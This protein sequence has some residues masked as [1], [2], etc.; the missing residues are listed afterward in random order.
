MGQIIPIAPQETPEFFSAEK[1]L[2]HE[3]ESSGLYVFHG[4]AEDR[5]ELSPQQA[6][7]ILPE[8]VIPD[9]EPAVF[10]SSLAD[11]AIFMAI[12]NKNNCPRGTRSSVWTHTTEGERTLSYGATAETLEQ[13]TDTAHG[14]VY[15]FNKESFMQ[16]DPEDEVE[17]ISTSTVK[18]IQKVRVLKQDLPGQIDIIEGQQQ[19]LLQ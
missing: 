7:N 11:Y 6:H 18:P 5:E 19:S 9:G 4:S 13:L 3:L 1:R 12:M 10:A 2:L 15:V 14:F 17:Y 8:G 16:R